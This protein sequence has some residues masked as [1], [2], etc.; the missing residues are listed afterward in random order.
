[1][2]K[3]YLQPFLG[4]SFPVQ[5]NINRLTA[6]FIQCEKAVPRAP[7]ACQ[8]HNCT[9]LNTFIT[10]NYNKRSTDTCFLFSCQ[11]NTSNKLNSILS[12][13]FQQYFFPLLSW[14]GRSVAPLVASPGTPGLQGLHKDSSATGTRVVLKFQP[15][16]YWTQNLV[17]VWSWA[18][19][20]LIV[21][22][23]IFLP[24]LMTWQLLKTQILWAIWLFGL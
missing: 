6:V 16:Q 11:Q 12:R 8:V 10:W 23:N 7:G 18:G 13:N 1:M 20:I 2:E 17:L 22:C 19:F 15:V 5:C 24:W 3:I 4:D 14:R 9:S 21:F